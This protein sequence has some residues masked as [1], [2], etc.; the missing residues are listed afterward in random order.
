MHEYVIGRTGHG[1]STYLEK[2]ALE[3]KG[4]FAFLDPHGDSAERLGEHVKYWSPVDDELGFNP[5]KDITKGQRHVVAAQVIASFKAI[6][7]ES[8]GPRME[9][10]LYNA[11]RVLL[12]TNGSLLDIP[13]LLTDNTYR[14]Q[15]LRHA[16][17]TDFWQ[18]EFASWDSKKRDEYIQPI[19]NKVGQLAAD[20]VLQKVLTQNNLSLLHLVN[21]GHKL[22][23]NLSKGQLGDG[24]SHLLGALLVTAIYQA[25]RSG[26]RRDF[27]LYADE[28]QNFA[29]DTFATI[30]S[31]ARKL[32]LHLVVA[33]QYLGQLSDS[34]RQAVFGNMG[35]FTVFNV[36]A[37]DAIILGREMD[38]AP[39]QL[40][41]LG[42][43]ETW[44]KE[45][46][47]VWNEGG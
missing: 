26:N 18:N 7:G 47:K 10:I 46:L 20:P 39:S 32:N 44:N 14:T 12:D 13:R 29:T 24:P 25:A 1:K 41:D 15:C 11:V 22:A 40:A 38:L 31:E 34:L 30:L 19:M 16:S 42:R 2:H 27:T 3:N 36:S 35:R 9:W 23:V 6:W 28:F 5:L 17:Y 21:S 8:W 37:E 45:G 4:G 33:H 43:F